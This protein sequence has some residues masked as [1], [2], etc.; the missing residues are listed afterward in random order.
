VVAPS[1]TVLKR[2]VAIELRRLRESA[3]FK[4]DEVAKRAGC[5]PSHIT[6]LEVARNL[7]KVP[8]L[9]LLLRHY[10]AANRIPAF[11]ELL[12]AARNGRDWWLPF[13]GVAPSWFDL[14]LGLE[15]IAEKIDSYDAVVIPALLQTPEY[16]EHSVR[17]VE[18]SL[19]NAEVAQRVELRMARRDVLTR[20]PEPPAV[21]TVL[22]ESA[23]YRPA[24]NEIV[25]AEQL[26]HIL[27][28]GELP[29]VT[30]QVLP[31]SAGMHAGISGTFV[32]LSFPAMLEN[33]PGVVYIEDRIRGTYHD[34]PGD[35]ARYRGTLARLQ[36][37][38]YSV[39][40]S[41]AVLQRRVE[42]LLR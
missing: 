39:E 4:R 32:L 20:E 2:Y 26:N 41:K 37:R 33:D 11:L 38:A 13:A 3:G 30:V 24:G 27:K 23:L 34:S 42:E 10:G 31:L 8:E 40:E 22:D 6:H 9:E 7:P 18:P 35:I 12:D 29:T 14:F 16:A 36:E 19:S 25:L 15:N 1:P 21:S 5:A 28:L 17:A